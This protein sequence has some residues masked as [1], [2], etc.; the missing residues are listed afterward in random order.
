[1]RREARAEFEARYTASQNF[2]SLMNIY[3]C[4]AAPPADARP[5]VAKPAREEAP[6]C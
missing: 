4:A 5:A 3:R 6:C 1:M 2:N